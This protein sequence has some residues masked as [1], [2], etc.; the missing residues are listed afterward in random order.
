M[1]LVIIMLFQVNKLVNTNEVVNEMKIFTYCPRCGRG[2]QDGNEGNK[3]ICKYCNFTYYHNTAA[4]VSAVIKYQDE[5]LMTVRMNDP[6]QGMLDLPGG[7]V[8]YDETLEQALSR[9]IAEEL[10]IVIAE[11]EWR[12]LFSYPNRYQYA[13]VEYY[14]SDAFFIHETCARPQTMVGEEVVDVVWLKVKNM[15]LERVGFESV[16]NAI[17]ALQTKYR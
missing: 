16:R 1:E 11:N 5:I 7:F 3:W 12:Y 14:T 15:T 9:E 2:E 13:G 10:R 6:V 8:D 17:K 4:A